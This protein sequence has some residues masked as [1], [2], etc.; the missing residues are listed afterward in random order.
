MRA[1]APATVANVAVGFDILGFAVPIL[2]DTVYVDIIDKGV[3][4]DGIIGKIN[5]VE[6]I[7]IEA[8]INTAGFALL[9]M[10]DDLD[11]D[12]GFKI[13]IEKAIPLGSGLGGSAAS[14]VAAIVAANAHLEQP[15]DKSGLL[16]YAVLGESIASGMHADNVAP[17]LF[18]GMTAVIAEDDMF[19]II[20]LPV[21]DTH[22]LI[23]HPDIVG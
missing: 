23:I 12:F 2:G 17:S 14:A 7:P 9:S 10:I 5:L 18:G 6:T 8:E 4:I 13:T 11:L 3:I 19:E 21:P 16:K 20:H 22:V 15:L 1:F